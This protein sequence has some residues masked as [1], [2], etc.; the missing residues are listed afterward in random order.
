MG[1]PRGPDVLTVRQDHD[2]LCYTA[3]G[4]AEAPTIRVR[5]GSDLTITLRNEIVDPAAIDAVTGPGKAYHRD[6]SC[7]AYPQ[8]SYP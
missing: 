1:A 7:A 2:R 3:N 8:T 5:L 6:G 4:S